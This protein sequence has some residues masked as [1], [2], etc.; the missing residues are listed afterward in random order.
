[1]LAQ[2]DISISIIFVKNGIDAFNFSIAGLDARQRDK[3]YDSI[4]LQQAIINR[5]TAFDDFFNPNLIRSCGRS[6]QHLNVNMENNQV[7]IVLAIMRLNK[8]YGQCPICQIEPDRACHAPATAF[9]VGSL[10]R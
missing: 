9:E 10:S 4:A 5:N 1:M 3:E 8:R 7:I 6:F 2:C